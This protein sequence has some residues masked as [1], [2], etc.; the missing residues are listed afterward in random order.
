MSGNLSHEI[1][2]Q[3][4]VQ[5]FGSDEDFQRRVA[6]EKLVGGVLQSDDNGDSTGGDGGSGTM[7]AFFTVNDPVKGRERVLQ[8]LGDAGELDEGMVVVHQAIPDDE[9]DADDPVEEIWWPADYAFRFSTFGPMWKGVPDQGELESLGE[10]LRALQGQWRVVR[11]DTADGSDA[12]SWASELRFLI[13]RDQLVAR[14]QVAV[15]SATRLRV[16]V[17]G[18]VDLRPLMGPNRGAVSLGRYELRGAELHLCM[19]PPGKP[20]PEAIAA[21][22]KHQPGRMILQRES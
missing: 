14:R 5:G 8:A 6:L 17:P 13:A 7:N 12:S 4:L 15:I 19:V 22:D 18:E 9:E 2:V 21:K 1:V 20:R 16:A 11:Y 10:G 3:F